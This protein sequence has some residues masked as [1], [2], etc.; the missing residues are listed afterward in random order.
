MARLDEAST[1]HFVASVTR[2]EDLEFEPNFF[3]AILDARTPTQINLIRKANVICFS[4]HAT[5]TSHAA[6]QGFIHANGKISRGTVARWLTDPAIGDIGW[7]P[8]TDNNRCTTY[9]AHPVIK[10]FLT[11]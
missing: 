5:D 6:V 9:T 1:W 4:A 7:T 11:N 10:Q 8:I 2:P 3:T